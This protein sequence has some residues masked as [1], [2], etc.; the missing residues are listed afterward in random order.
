MANTKHGLPQTRG[1]FKL[2]GLATGM[3]RDNA[4]KKTEYDSGSEKHTLNFGIETAPESTVY[5]QIEG[6]KNDTAY[7]FKRAE[8]KGE[9]GEKKQV[10]WEDRYKYVEDGFNVIGVS[11]GI[12]KDEDG[13]NI[14]ETLID[15]DAVYKVRHNVEDGTPLFVR[16]DIDFSSFKNSSTGEIRRNK[17]FL[18]K[19]IYLS[20]DI[21]FEAENFE[22]TS[23]FKQ[24]IVFMGI[25]KSDEPGDTKFVVE[26]K[27][28][29]RNS[30]ED[31][32]FIVRNN[33]LANQFRKA[34]KPYTAID[35]W[36]KIFNKVDTDEV[37]ES[38]GTVWG[39]EDSFKR[40]TRNYIRELVITG[41]DPET[42]DTETYTEEII[43]EAIKKL[44]SQGQ[45]NN[46]STNSNDD[47]PW[48][49]GDSTGLKD[50]DLPW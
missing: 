35:V 49:E 29:T 1:F 18:V 2:R 34:L 37:E 15:A 31:T 50:D 13:K 33:G 19:N 23:D 40:V 32:E 47:N 46:N 20:G 36:G 38:S 43:E 11:V 3:Q 22:E 27:I 9:Q 14:T 41:A 5:A 24:R 10:P 44:N 25:A 6:F 4:V 16:G 7:L 21:D 42:I 45:V 28:I 12:T 48:G 17:K 39:E 30:I 8:I 26:A